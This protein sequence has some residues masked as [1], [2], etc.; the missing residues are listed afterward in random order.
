VAEN[1]GPDCF[2]VLV[3]VFGHVSDD[4]SC[5]EPW[6]EVFPVP[7]LGPLTTVQ[8]EGPPPHGGAFAVIHPLLPDS[9]A[10]DFRPEDQCLFDQFTDQIGA[11]RITDGDLDGER[12]CDAG[13]VEAPT[14]TAPAPEPEPPPSPQLPDTALPARTEG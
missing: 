2:G 13:A 6:I 5:N 3:S 1:D 7:G 4:R 9:D 12:E 10:I 8:R 14:G 11:P